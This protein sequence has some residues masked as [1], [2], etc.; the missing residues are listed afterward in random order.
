MPTSARCPLLQAL[1]TSPVATQLQH[2]QLGYSHSYAACTAA[3]QQHQAGNA[4]PGQDLPAALAQLLKACSA[5]ESLQLGYLPL[6][7][8]VLDAVGAAA[9]Q[10]RRLRRLALH[11]CT[12]VSR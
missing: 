1:A 11:A 2:L 3:L 4:A 12:G 5:L 6:S 7:S 9:G 8:A 10:A